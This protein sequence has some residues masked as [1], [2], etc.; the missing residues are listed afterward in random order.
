M[1]LMK[2]R[3]SADHKR[4]SATA[5]PTVY[6][7]V[8]AIQRTA[9]SI[10]E[11]VLVAAE[12][13]RAV[14][15]TIAGLPILADNTKPMR[16]SLPPMGTELTDEEKGTLQSYKVARR[17]WFN[18]EAVRRSKTTQCLQIMSVARELRAEPAIY[19]PQQV[20]YRGRAYAVP[21]QLNPQSNDLAKGLLIFSDG[22]PLGYMG[23]YWLAVHGANTFGIDKGP[24]ADRVDWVMEHE[25]EILGSASDP[26]GCQ[27]W[28][29]ADGGTKPWQFLAFC[30]EWAAYVAGGES[31]EFVSHLPVGMDGSANG[32]QHFSAMLRDPKGAHATNMTSAP[33]Q[34]IYGVVAAAVTARI[35]GPQ[36]TAVDTEM[37]GIWKEYGITRSLVKRPVMTT[38]YGA[39]S[40]GMKE[41]ILQDTIRLE[42]TLRWGPKPWETADWIAKVIYEAIGETVQ[43]SQSAK[44]YLQNIAQVAGK[45]EQAVT[46]TTPAGLPV[47]QDIAMTTSFEVNTHLMGRIRLRFAETTPRLDKRKQRSSITPNF[48]HSYDAAHLMLTVV[49]CEL[50]AGGPMSW[51]MVHDSFGTHAGDVQMM[52]RILR[53]EFIAM[54]RDSSPLSELGERMALGLVNGDKIGP[55][56]EMGS[57]DLE[58]VASA[59]FFFA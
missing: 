7:A 29:E 41:M 55:A 11:D 25:A 33:Q 20:D 44:E 54:Y 46:W 10:N 15:S 38:P 39:T 12:L 36:A 2:T 19:F 58:E 23:A 37:A 57:F 6:E 24:L 49:A 48:V 4:L 47:V 30:L 35:S 22:R 42:P 59:E 14:S 51:A 13:L 16:P 5:M 28:S 34:D 43:A 53:E 21:S 8:N 52:S 40:I 18:G 50:E 17:T 32:I 31:P 1:T 9:W 3:K 26:L 56:P 27:W 45:E